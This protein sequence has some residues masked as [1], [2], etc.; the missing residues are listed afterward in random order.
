MPHRVIETHGAIPCGGR[1][2]VALAVWEWLLKE[3]DRAEAAKDRARTGI[4]LSSRGSTK[5]IH[6]NTPF[7]YYYT[8]GVGRL[9]QYC[10]V[11]GTRYQA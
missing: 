6:D 7:A 2:F 3:L 11:Q 10:L 5:Y 9:W 8:S 4:G 1:V